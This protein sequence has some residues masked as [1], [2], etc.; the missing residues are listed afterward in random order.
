VKLPGATAFDEDPLLDDPDFLIRWLRAFPQLLDP[1]VELTSAR[2][3]E[4]DPEQLA[5]DVHRTPAA[6]IPE[7][8]RTG[9]LGFDPGELEGRPRMPGS[10]ALAFLH[11]I[12]STRV[13]MRKWWKHT[14]EQRWVELFD[15]THKPSYSEVAL[16]FG[17]LE[18][19][20]RERGAFHGLQRALVRNA[21]THRPEIGQHLTYDGTTVQT[22][23]RLHHCCPDRAA[24]RADGSRPR[25]IV[26]R[27]NEDTIQA[28][29]KTE[30]EDPFFDPDKPPSGAGS[31]IGVKDGFAYFKFGG[32]I[33]RSEDAASGV[34]AYA[35]GSRVSCWFGSLGCVV[36]DVATDGG[37][38]AEAIAADVQ[39]YAAWPSVLEQITDLL[40]EAP[41]TVSFDGLSSISKVYEH[42]TRRGVAT[43]APAKQRGKLTREETRKAS[44]D[45]H[46]I[47]RCKH[48]GG[49]GDIDAPK[50]GLTFQKG[51]PFL[52]FRCVLQLT[53]KCGET[54]RIACCEDWRLLTPLSRKTLLYHALRRD[55]R[56]ME[57][58][59]GHWRQR[60]RVFGKDRGGMLQKNGTSTQ[61]LRAKASLVIE[62]LRINIRH[63]WLGDHAQVNPNRVRIDTGVGAKRLHNTLLGRR[64]RGLNLP[65]GPR[66]QHLGL[67]PPSPA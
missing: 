56:K 6:R 53:D 27:A 18:L 58:L 35:S 64:R 33:Y 1:L 54:Q 2:L 5:P 32:H 21:R 3:V 10:W 47:P 20:E 41:Y 9:R 8:S 61:R 28:A 51:E 25:R 45:E 39:E 48:C 17:E 60:Y 63:G 4:I 14:D 34:R 59:F 12:A 57:K 46:G 7:C 50:L 26:E 40:G 24:C 62:W 30:I 13:A 66:A 55:H 31:F 29:R 52:R 38:A 36:A 22:R 16:R 15:F 44:F 11:Y 49:E 37:L 65:Y 42:N 19:I 23:A 43:I 67:A